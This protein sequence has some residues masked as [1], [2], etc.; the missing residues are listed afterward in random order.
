[1][2][3][4]PTTPFGGVNSGK[5]GLHP[6]IVRSKRAGEKTTMPYLIQKNAD[7]T[8]R[9]KWDVMD[10]PLT[11]GRGDQADLQIDDEEMSRRHFVIERKDGEYTLRDL[12]KR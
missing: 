4:E 5:W 12:G 9:Q 1:M 6:V 7:G 3:A 2:S 8:V 11:V 10:K